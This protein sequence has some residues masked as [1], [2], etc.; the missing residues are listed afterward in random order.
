[1]DPSRKN[2]ENNPYDF[3]DNPINIQ[4]EINGELDLNEDNFVEQEEI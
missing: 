3:L 2:L 4:N 1:M